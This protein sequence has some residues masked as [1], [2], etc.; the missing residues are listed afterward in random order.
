MQGNG[1]RTGRRRSHFEGQSGERAQPWAQL[2]LRPEQRQGA[3]ASRLPSLSIRSSRSWGEARLQGGTSTVS[4]STKDGNGFVSSS[5]KIQVQLS[6]RE[7][8]PWSWVLN[9]GLAKAQKKKS[10]RRF[11]W[12]EGE[13]VGWLKCSVNRLTPRA[14]AA[15][16]PCGGVRDVLGLRKDEHGLEATEGSLSWSPSC[17]QELRGPLAQGE[18]ADRRYSSGPP[19]ARSLSWIRM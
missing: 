1:K 9:Y 12:T 7:F 5:E 19:D 11:C 2:G 6:F 8:L 16:S 18:S 15:F 4:L 13:R 17:S 10:R 14:W 3:G